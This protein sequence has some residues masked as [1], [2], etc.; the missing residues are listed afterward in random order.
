MLCKPL[1]H[2][3]CH[4]QFDGNPTNKMKKECFIGIDCSTQSTKA[5]LF[6]A[7]GN[8]LDEARTEYSFMS[9]QNGWAEQNANEL[10]ES[11]CSALRK[12]CDKLQGRLLVGMGI[13]YQR[14]TFVVLD[15]KGKV[16]RPAI[17]WLDQRSLGEVEEIERDIG[18]DVFQKLTGKILNT[19]PSLPKLRWIRNNE[20]ELYGK[21]DKF[22]D[23]GAFLNMKLTGN[24]ISPYSGADTSG[25]FALE[26]KDWSVDLL[27]YMGLAR[28]NMP[29]VVPA[30]TCVGTISETAAEASGLPRGL[31]VFAAG[32]DG[33]VF[34]LGTGS[35]GPDTVALSLGTSV[36]WGV[37]STAYTTSS[38]FRT[39]M[40]CQPDTFY[41]ESA[42]VSGSHTIKWFIDSMAGEET[43][44]AASRNTSPEAVL[45]EEIG[46]IAPGCDGLIT[47]PYWRGVMNPYNNPGARGATLGWSDYH[48]RYHFYRSILEGIAF[49]LRT[50]IA[51]YGDTLQLNP[52]TIRIGS[53]GARSV[54]WQQ[55]ISDVNGMDIAISESFENTALGAAMIAA[56]GSGVYGDLTEASEHMSR[57]K[58]HIAPDEENCRIYTRLYEDVYRQ[59]FPAVDTYLCML[60]SYGLRK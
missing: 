13:A 39:M 3:V 48:T 55:I 32:G 12:L 2:A 37:H 18:G 26:T 51:G 17:L 27:S 21:I 11:L 5:V 22:C 19:L 24:L 20:P 14:E 6:N 16:I 4:S 38:H 60:S 10:W 53:G 40:G 35:L 8:V 30:G 49:E 44:R 25:L 57:M 41:C 31:P 33:Q 54:I 34:A 42:I 7:E 46:T 50:V 47:L 52:H 1:R 58:K 43:T 9:P 59:I 23:V 56:W 28:K 15:A 29:E 45:E 36:V